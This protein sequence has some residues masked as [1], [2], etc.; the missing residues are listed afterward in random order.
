MHSE[1]EADTPPR[2]RYEATVP[3]VQARLVRVQGAGMGSVSY[4]L[5]ATNQVVGRGSAEIVFSADS[6]VSPRH[7]MFYI[8]DNAF[9]V[10]D[11]S[12]L[13]GV[14]VRIRDRVDL[15]VGDQFLVGEQLFEV[16][17][18][19]RVGESMDGEMT[20]FFGSLSNSVKW[21]INQ[22]L[23]GGRPGL[24]R[25]LSS[26]DLS[27]GRSGCEVDFPADRFISGRHC[28]IRADDDKVEL[29]DDSSRNGTYLRMDAPHKLAEGD[30]LFIGKQLLRVELSGGAS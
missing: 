2:A 11:E 4:P 8:E 1:V 29:I 26:T 16:S 13:N 10:R 14:F 19:Q 24:S 22:I 5:E 9:F 21:R 20:H 3:P 28:V 15:K 6:Y 7:A 17:L 12:S 30:H 27:I 18:N 23:D 25:D